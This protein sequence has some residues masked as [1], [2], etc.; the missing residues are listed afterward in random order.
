MGEPFRRSFDKGRL[1]GL[2]EP[3]SGSSKATAISRP[4]ERRLPPLPAPASSRPRHRVIAS[5]DMSPM[6]SNGHCRAEAEDGHGGRYLP[7]IFAAAPR[8]RTRRRASGRRTAPRPLPAARPA[9]IGPLTP[10]VENRPKVSSI[11][12]PSGLPPPRARTCSG[13]TTRTTPMVSS[14]HGR[15]G[16]ERSRRRARAQSQ[17]WR[18]TGRAR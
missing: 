18:R 10:C 14:K 7:E 12:L 17:S 8:A 13:L 2:V 6:T 15:D 3:A 11:V 5:R 9:R 16:C 4:T 1:D